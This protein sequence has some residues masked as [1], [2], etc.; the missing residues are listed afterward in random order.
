VASFTELQRELA[1]TENKI[2]AARRF[3]KSNVMAFNTKQEVFPSKLVSGMLGFKKA[4]FFELV[5]QA[6]REPVKVAF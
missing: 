2:Q 1:D 5:E 6:A 3:Y 4:D